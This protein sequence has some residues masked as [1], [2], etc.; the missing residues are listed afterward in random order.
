[1]NPKPI[2]KRTRT[3]GNTKQKYRGIINNLQIGAHVLT[4]SN[5]NRLIAYYG[6]SK[7]L[8]KYLVDL[9][10]L[11]EAGRGR[12]HVVFEA[13][14]NLDSAVDTLY[15]YQLSMSR[16]ANNKKKQASEKEKQLAITLR[17]SIEV[18]PAPVG[19]ENEPTHTNVHSIDSFIATLSD[20]TL[21]SALI[22]RGY[23]ILKDASK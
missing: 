14:K 18:E 17:E 4:R 11:K 20:G 22:K 19:W 12:Y 23:I 7:T 9:A 21:I 2:K 6:V 15:N 3:G 10:F 13:I 16:I 1:M 5:I 8:P